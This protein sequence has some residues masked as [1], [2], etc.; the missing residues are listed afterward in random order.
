[1]A[2]RKRRWQRRPN[3]QRQARRPDNN[4]PRR[5][6][7][8]SAGSV[9]EWT[10]IVRYPLAVAT[11]NQQEDAQDYDHEFYLENLHRILIRAKRRER[12]ILVHHDDGSI[13]VL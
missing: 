13:E 4:E 6:D 5:D 11:P 10:S 9:Q 1:M 2:R 7:D 3:S 8:D 12:I